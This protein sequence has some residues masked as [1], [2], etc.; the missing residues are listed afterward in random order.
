M[1]IRAHVQAL[2]ERHEHA[3]IVKFCAEA[4]HHRQ[5]RVDRIFLLLKWACHLAALNPEA[6]ISQI[7]AS[8]SDALDLADGDPEL[9]ARILVAQSAAMTPLGVPEQVRGILRQFER[10][11]SLHAEPAVTQYEGDIL[12]NVARAHEAIGQL[13]QAEVWYRRA[14]RHFEEHN[15]A[16]KIGKTLNNLAHICIRGL[17]VAEAQRL[18]DRAREHVVP[19]IVELIVQSRIALACHDLHLARRLLAEALGTPDIDERTR[20]QALIAWADVE[21]A[22]GHRSEAADRAQEALA[23]AYRLPYREA[24]DHLEGFLVT[25]GG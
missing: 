17:R 3:A 16:T 4:L 14:L 13:L 6:W 8:L 7:N 22:D 9:Q 10:L 21:W 25:K 5:A 18:A 19:G 1:N 20:V 23:L 15:D 2:E 11:S 24:I 12:Y